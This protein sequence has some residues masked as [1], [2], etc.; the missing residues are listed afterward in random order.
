MVKINYLVNACNDLIFKKLLHDE[1]IYKYFI[2]L[3]TGINFDG[4]KL[5]YVDGEIN[6]TLKAKGVRFDVRLIVDNK[7]DIDI[8]MQLRKD[9]NTKNMEFR[10]RSYFGDMLA[11]SVPKGKR[12]SDAK[13]CILII[14]ANF[15]INKEKCIN[16]FKIKDEDSGALTNDK[17]YII[18]LTKI[19]K[20]DNMK[21]QKWLKILTSNNPR[22]YY[23]EDEIMDRAIDL[24]YEMNDK[25]YYKV[26]R[27]QEYETN[28]ISELDYVENQGIKK[29]KKEGHKQGK[30]EGIKEIITALYEN[31]FSVEAIAKSTNMSVEEV[32]RILDL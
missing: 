30:Q 32:K 15:R 7:F 10:I 4:K 26:R 21:L 28:Y 22:E 17:I 3:I 18:D 20:C 2:S 11:T 25:E 9:R 14:F 6:P 12:Y 24:I 5:E 19:S 29:G 31:N 23:G 1:V 13:E 8:E 27:L 16:T